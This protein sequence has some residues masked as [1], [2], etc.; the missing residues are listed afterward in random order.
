[1]QLVNDMAETGRRIGGTAEVQVGE[2]RADVP[3]GTVMAMIDQ[4]IKVTEGL[5]AWRK[6][7]EAAAAV[8]PAS[9]L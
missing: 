9:S 6:R 2:G 3:V 5:K 7:A 1:M 8:A 4:A